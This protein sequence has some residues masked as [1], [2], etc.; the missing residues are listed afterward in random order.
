MSG[1]LNADAKKKLV[2]HAGKAAK[3]FS[4]EAQKFI[5]STRQDHVLRQGMDRAFMN[6]YLACLKQIDT[7]LNQKDLN[8]MGAALEQIEKRVEDA[9]NAG[10]VEI[11]LDDNNQPIRVADA[12]VLPDSGNPESPSPDKGPGGST[13][14]Q[15]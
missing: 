8:P 6:G 10:H 7:L 15:K 1:F 12:S 13:E 4:K 5:V 9:K 11:Q 3:K 14:E 2:D